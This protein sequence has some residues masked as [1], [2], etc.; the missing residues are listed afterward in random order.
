CRN[1]ARTPASVQHRNDCE[2]LFIGRVSDHIMSQGLKPK[3]TRRQ[4]G[5]TMATE[6]KRGEGFNRVVNFFQSLV[7]SVKAIGGNVVPDFGEIGVRLRVEDKSA[8]ERARRSLLLS[9]R[10]AKASSPSTDFTRPFL[11]SS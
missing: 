1:H 5:T 7:G 6:R 4:V 8:H 9:L 11:R 3:R 10:L 2:R